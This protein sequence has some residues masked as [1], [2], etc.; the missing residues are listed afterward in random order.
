MLLPSWTLKSYLGQDLCPDCFCCLS[1]FSRALGGC[2]LPVPQQSAGPHTASSHQVSL[3]CPSHH[4]P[5]LFPSMC[6][7]YQSLCGPVCCLL[8]CSISFHGQ[9]LDHP[10]K[11]AQSLGTCRWSLN[12]PTLVPRLNLSYSLGLWLGQQLRLGWDI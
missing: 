5:C 2:L 12:N 4:S 1:C 6:I 10:R 7:S 9:A 8:P 11:V 3:T